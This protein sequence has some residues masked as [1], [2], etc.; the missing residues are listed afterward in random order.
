VFSPQQ[1]LDKT[2]KVLNFSSVLPNL[3]GWG[4]ACGIFEGEIGHEQLN[5][6]VDFGSRMAK[7]DGTSLLLTMDKSNTFDLAFIITTRPLLH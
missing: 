5:V 2:P 3:R 7:A 6:M 4:K 1:T